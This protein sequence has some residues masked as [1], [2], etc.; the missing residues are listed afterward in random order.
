[1]KTLEWGLAALALAMVASGSAIL[2]STQPPAQSQ[3][4]LLD[5]LKAEG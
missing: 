1:M 3:P 5:Q 2:L 4:L